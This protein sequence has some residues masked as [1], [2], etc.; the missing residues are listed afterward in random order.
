MPGKPKVTI[1][2]AISTTVFSLPLYSGSVLRKSDAK[3][4]KLHAG[5][6]EDGINLVF[7]ISKLHRV[8]GH[9]LARDGH[10]MNGG[11]VKVLYA[12]DQTQ[13][14]EAPVLFDGSGFHLDFLPEGQYVL[15]VEGGKDVTHIQVANPTGYTPAVRE[16]SKTLQTYPDFQQPL[17]VTG[18][19]SNFVASQPDASTTNTAPAAT[20]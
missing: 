18:D 19:L 1:N 13:L 4:W 11:T 16:D 15:K 9:V 10:A 7:P 20:Q 14:T 3:A 6:A 17:V 2:F 8:T 12:D 5:E